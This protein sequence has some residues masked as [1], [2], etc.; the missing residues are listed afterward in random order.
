MSHVIVVDDND[1]NLLLLRHI[2]LKLDD[3]TVDTFSDPRQALDWCSLYEPDLVLL[4]YMMP[5]MDGMEFMRRF[6]ALP[7]RQDVP[8]VMVT[9]DTERDVRHLALQMGARDFL[10]KPV[11]K[12]ELTV[13]VRNLLALR[14]SSQQLANRAAWLLEEVKKATAEIRAREKEAIL[15]LSRAAEY[16]DPETGAHLLRMSSYARLIARELGLPQQEQEMLQEAA[17]MHDIG[18]VGIPDAILLKPGKLTDDE[19]AIMRQHPGFG[20]EILNDSVSPLL[21]CAA[22]V[23]LSHHEKFDGSGY[24]SGLTGEAIPLWGR[25]VAVADV[26]DALT[27]DRPYKRAWPLDDARRYLED[28]KGRHFDPVCVDALF[29]A[30]E[31][32]Q[33]IREQ[34]ADEKVPPTVHSPYKEGGHHA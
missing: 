24:P 31:D 27:S 1:T 4:D 34:F 16:R 17:P 20:H 26:F 25:I 11:D 15:R 9:A 22:V 29:A 19:M 18:K 33:R 6:L 7:Q 14:K 23:A 5:E 28:E 13:R 3:V 10:T 2:L 32:V 8:V 21:Q 12:V 30:W